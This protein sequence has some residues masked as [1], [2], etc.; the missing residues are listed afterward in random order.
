MRVK[1]APGHVF[2]VAGFS[3]GCKLHDENCDGAN[4][5]QM[6]HAAFV[7]KNGQDKPNNKEYCRYKPEFHLVYLLYCFEARLSDHEIVLA[8]KPTLSERTCAPAA[9]ALAKRVIIVCAGSFTELH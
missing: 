7:K 8:I 2:V 5:K 6:H 9:I 4:Q 1:L 3:E